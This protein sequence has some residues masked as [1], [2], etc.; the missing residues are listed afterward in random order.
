[1]LTFDVLPELSLEFT[2]GTEAS[3][4][5]MLVAHVVVTTG[6]GLF[7]SLKLSEQFNGPILRALVDEGTGMQLSLS[8]L[9]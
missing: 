7:L 6:T 2:C 9:K 1:M 3:V 5:Y 4:A 8:I